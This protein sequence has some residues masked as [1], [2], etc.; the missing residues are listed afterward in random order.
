[1]SDT[2]DKPGTTVPQFA[3]TLSDLDNS[4][5][6]SMLQL[7]GQENTV[8]GKC[9]RE[10]PELNES[11][12]SVR[13]Q[14]KPSSYDKEIS[15]ESRDNCMLKLG[16]LPQDIKKEKPHRNGS[17]S[18]LNAHETGKSTHTKERQVI[19]SGDKSYSVLKAQIQ[20]RIKNECSTRSSANI[21]GTS[22]NRVHEPSEC[23]K[24]NHSQPSR[25]HSMESASPDR[26]DENI[27]GNESSTNE[28]YTHRRTKYGL[29]PNSNEYCESATLSI[30]VVDTAV[31]TCSYRR[32][33]GAFIHSTPSTSQQHRP[34][35][36][37]PPA[38]RP[39]P[40][41]SPPPSKQSLSP[42]GSESRSS[43]SPIS[44]KSAKRYRTRSRS[45]PRHKRSRS[46]SR[47]RSISR[48]YRSHRPRRRSKSRSKSRSR[49]RSSSKTAKLRRTSSKSPPHRKRSRSGS[50]SVKGSSS[51]SHRSY[52]R[53][54]SRSSSPRSPASQHRS[55]K[56]PPHRKPCR[57]RSHSRE[58]SSIR[59]RRSYKRSRSRSCSPRSPASRQRSHSPSLTTEKNVSVVTRVTR[60]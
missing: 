29:N 2:V 15:K 45:P 1:M 10:T 33:R 52:E 36:I 19:E 49:S 26:P 13:N 22:S 40:S 38:N 8:I 56:S 31:T 7:S 32:E 37:S 28:T 3:E 12:P 9:E 30:P 27:I 6:S 46:H 51:R 41:W 47:E 21:C 4:Q 42:S 5:Q 53:S 43:R 16:N 24:E 35:S 50:H 54:R 34:Q 11:S 44:W 18:S 48:S 20:R 23:V 39:Q 55:S 57:S 17:E 25:T 60:K 59:S 58:G 14:C